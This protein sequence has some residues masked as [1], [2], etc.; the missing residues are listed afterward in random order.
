MLFYNSSGS[1]SN[2]L[3]NIQKIHPSATKHEKHLKR[4]L[5]NETTSTD[6]IHW[7]IQENALSPSIPPIPVKR[8]DPRLTQNMQDRQ[9]QVRARPASAAGKLR[10]TEGITRSRWRL[11]LH[12]IQH[13][14]HNYSTR[15]SHNAPQIHD[16]LRRAAST[17]AAV[18][19]ATLLFQ[20]PSLSPSL[21]LFF[22]GHVARLHRREGEVTESLFISPH[23]SPCR[24]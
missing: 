14:T 2:R 11:P 22:W 20:A 1:I 18:L 13:R 23:C 12:W 3:V 15:W 5:R 21:S 9:T 4:D 17:A 8:T 16:M 7:I 19:L 10:D 24:L 6:L